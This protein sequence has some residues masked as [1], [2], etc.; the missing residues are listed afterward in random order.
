MNLKLYPKLIELKLKFTL[1]ENYLKCRVWILVFST[2]YVQ[3]KYTCLVTL[4]DLKLQFFKNSPNWPIF[5]FLLNFFLSTQIDS[6]WLNLAHF[7]IFLLIFPHFPSFWLICLI[8]THIDSNWLILTAMTI[9][10]ILTHF[11]SLL[12]TFHSNWLTLT[13]FDHFDSFWP[14]W[15][16][17]TQF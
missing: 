14:F 3:L 11:D 9:F 7:Y 16:K 10:V 6:F 13:Y 2:N 1:F 12:L 17:L 15:L 8:Y 5:A 4:F